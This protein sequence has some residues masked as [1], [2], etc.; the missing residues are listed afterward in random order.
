MECVYLRISALAHMLGVTQL[1]VAMACILGFRRSAGLFYRAYRNEYVTVCDGG[2]GR[3]AADGPDVQAAPV[4]AGQDR[5]GDSGQQG[6]R[7]DQPF[8]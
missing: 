7:D 3:L 2:P 1:T 5:E 4:Q 6:Y 8:E